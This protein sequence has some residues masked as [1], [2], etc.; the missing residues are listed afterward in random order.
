[1]AF[2]LL[3]A[4]CADLSFDLPYDP[5]RRAID[6]GEVLPPSDCAPPGSIPDA[7]GCECSDGCASG[8][9]LTEEDS[10]AEQGYGI[11]QGIC[12]HGC[13]RDDEC[14]EG[15]ACITDGG[16]V[17]VCYKECRFIEDCPPFNTCGPVFDGMPAIC[18]PLCQA[19]ADCRGG[20]CDVWT[21]SCGAMS[22]P[23]LGGIGAPCSDPSECRGNVCLS[24]G[25]CSVDCSIYRQL[26]PGDA[27]CI[28]DLVRDDDGT[29]IP[30]CETDADCAG[31]PDSSC[32][33][34]PEAG[35]RGCL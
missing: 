13:T 19:D 16:G 2:V 6:T 11:P 20:A 10:L 5:S 33:Y 17:G 21:G 18:R 29:C 22:D 34:F 7:F 30:A 27:I 12:I 24:G 31:V 3:L 28:D 23:S 15:Y 25:F 26:C 32:V 1:M 9:C 14:D 35:A 4:G 8:L